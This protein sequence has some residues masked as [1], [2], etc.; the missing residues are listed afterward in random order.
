MLEQTLQEILDEIAR[1]K[2]D[3]LAIW[4]SRVE[5]Y[6]RKKSPTDFLCVA[7]EATQFCLGAEVGPQVTVLR[8]SQCLEEIVWLMAEAINATGL[9]VAFYDALE[10][11]LNPSSL[12]DIIS[13]LG[14]EQRIKIYEVRGPGNGWSEAQ[15][16]VVKVFE[17]TRTA[18][19]R[20]ALRA[21][22]E[23]QAKKPFVL[24]EQATQELTDA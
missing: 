14:R 22:I 9:E 17:M 4:P 2:P 15:R 6:D 20:M 24:P 3:H 11:E 18:H 23:S 19:G 8:D 13:Y 7:A 10:W 16:D 1:I 5:R 12:D 21:R